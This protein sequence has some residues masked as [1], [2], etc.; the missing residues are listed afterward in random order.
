MVKQVLS[1]RFEIDAPI[2]PDY[3]L[4]LSAVGP[5]PTDRVTLS[6]PALRLGHYKVDGPEGKEG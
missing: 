6:I 5:G 2:Q 1:D 3:W 4:S